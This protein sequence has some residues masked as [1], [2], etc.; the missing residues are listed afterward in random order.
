MPTSA[1]VPWVVAAAVIACSLVLLADERDANDAELQYQLASLLYEETRYIEALQAFDRAAQTTDATLGIRARKGR[2]RSALKVAEF[3]LARQEAQKLVGQAPSDAEAQTLF[4]DT[5]WSAGL[6]DEA[7][8]SYKTALSLSAG[9]PACTF[10]PGPFARDAEQ[11]VRGAGRGPGRLG[12]RATGRRH[13]RRHRRHL[14]AAE[15]LRRSRQR[16]HQLHQP[17]A[18]QRPQRKGRLGARPGPVPRVLRGHEAG[19]R[20]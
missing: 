10:R 4:A 12:G 2:V 11:A 8:R 18:E 19:G 14:R 13:P 20:G 16:V 7:D 15:P 6:F 1:R 9:Y 17:A 5:L 3:G